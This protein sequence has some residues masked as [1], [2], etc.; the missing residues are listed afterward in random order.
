MAVIWGL[1]L[2]EMQWGKFK[3]SYMF[4]QVYHL[5]C[6][7]MIVYQIAM[8]L[9]VCSE[10]VGTAAL[11][12]YVDQQDA[13]SRLSAGRAMVHNSDIVGIF[14]YNIFVG[15]AVATIFGSGFFFDLFWPERQESRAVKM[16]W[17]VCS[18][19]VSLMALADALAMTLIIAT[20]KAH[21]SGVSPVAAELY[22]RVNGPPNRIYRKNAYNVASVCLLWPG[23]VASFAST[24]IMHRS[25]RHNEVHG[26]KAAAYRDAA[27]KQGEEA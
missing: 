16:A 21:I 19:V 25:L 7:K 22:V 11:T 9:C 5:R 4:N 10:S 3:G 2:H 6:T 27:P 26:P 23:V 15:I 18:V 13:I 20:H 12:D 14:S 8:I 1:D 17:K 24:Y